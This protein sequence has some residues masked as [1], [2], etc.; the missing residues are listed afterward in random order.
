MIYIVLYMLSLVEIN[1]WNKW[2]NS[3][4]CL[5]Y[6]TFVE[7]PLFLPIFPKYLILL[8]LYTFPLTWLK[9]VSLFLFTLCIHGVTENIKLSETHWQV[10]HKNFVC[11]GWK[12]ICSSEDWNSRVESLQ[13]FFKV[14]WV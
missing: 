12:T 4:F 6:L 10:L 5:P 11:F 14:P 3:S 13:L 9:R 2:M 7:K 8:V 1:E